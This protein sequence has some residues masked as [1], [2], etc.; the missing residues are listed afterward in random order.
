M[1]TKKISRRSVGVAAAMVAAALSLSACGSGTTPSA[2]ET[3]PVTIRFAWWGGDARQKLTQ[4][5]IDAFEAEN[6]NITVE[7]E[8]SDWNGYWD[9]LA[10]QVAANDAPDVFQMDEQYLREYSDRGALLD[11][12]KLNGF[13][14]GDIDEAVLKSGEVDG[15]TFAVPASVNSFAVAANTQLLNQA[16]IALPDDKTWSW[17]DY[18]SIAK[19]VA[20]KVPG[21]IGTGGGYSDPD[22]NT[23]ARQNGDQLFDN[24]SNVV[25]KPETVVS[26][27]ERMLR[28]SE[29]GAAPS[30]AAIVEGSGGSINQSP[31][32]TGKQALGI[33][34][35][36]QISAYESAGQDLTL[37]RLPGESQ[38]KA[39]SA[40]Y[41]P[42]MFW[43]VSS[44]TKHQAAAQ[45]FLDFLANSETAGNILLTERGIPANTKVRNAI[46]EKLNPKDKEALDFINTIKDD[47]VSPPPITPSGASGTLQTFTRYSQDILFGR[48]SPEKAAPA[49]IEEL[50]SSIKK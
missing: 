34:F 42:G 39:R 17:E 2:E 50:R 44:R 24:E 38:A 45:K 23:W 19:Q 31:L 3:G 43:A 6:P 26:Y 33:I 47:V 29:T 37:L 30:A 13:Q 15:E 49:F 20:E 40:Y 25:I 9:K 35:N 46:A 1:K 18:E 36:N 10:T 16:G 5:A 21:T 7:G 48:T 12:K 11:L 4:Q 27:W 41:K 32:G 8:Y 28:L 22:L 14:T